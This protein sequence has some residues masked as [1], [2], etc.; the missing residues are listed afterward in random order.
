LLFYPP[1]QVSCVF[2]P[3]LASN[4]DPPTCASHVA[5]IAVEH[6]HPSFFVELMG[7]H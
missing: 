4:S 6:P 5:G 2:C 7:S 3:W 1:P